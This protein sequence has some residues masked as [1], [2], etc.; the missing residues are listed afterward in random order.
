MMVVRVGARR[1]VSTLRSVLSDSPARSA[2]TGRDNPA[3]CRRCTRS[4]PQAR[5]ATASLLVGST[6]PAARWSC[7]TAV[8][9]DW[10]AC[11][12]S[13]LGKQFRS[14]A[15]AR[16]IA[17]RSVGEPLLLKRSKTCIVLEKA[18]RTGMLSNC[19]T[20]SSKRC[21]TAN[22]HPTRNQAV[23]VGV[24][25]VNSPP[26][27][28]LADSLCSGNHSSTGNQGITRSARIHRTGIGALH[29][30]LLRSIRKVRF[31]QLTPPSRF[32]IFMRI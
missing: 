15:M 21:P 8:G 14:V 20:T 2:S 11:S 13:A 19:S 28:Y 1:P 3:A 6:I 31:I 10:L 17:S 22:T 32:H 26:H 5:R 24:S 9:G 30:Q 27:C 29:H 12:F 25:E 23:L 7:S 4:A 16:C 18:S